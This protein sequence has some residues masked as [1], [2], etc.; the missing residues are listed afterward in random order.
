[1]VGN[2]PN[3]QA[4]ISLNWALDS[5]WNVNVEAVWLG[6]VERAPG[7]PRD[8]MDSASLLNFTVTRMDVWQ[9][10]EVALNVRN[11]LDEDWHTPSVGSAASVNVPNDYPAPGRNANITVRYDFE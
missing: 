8:P 9:D 7:D 11:L 6:R 2:A 1:D 3:N 10:W 5:D 4:Y